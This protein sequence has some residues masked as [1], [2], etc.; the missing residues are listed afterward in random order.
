MLLEKKTVC[1]DC[2]KMVL[3]GALTYLL[4]LLFQTRVV[5]VLVVAVGHILPDRC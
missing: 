5:L 2:F 4:P 1:L 3:S